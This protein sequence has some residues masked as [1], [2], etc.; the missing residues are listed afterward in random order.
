VE[1][2][3]PSSARANHRGRCWACGASDHLQRDCPSRSRGGRKSGEF[4]KR[5]RRSAVAGQVRAPDSDQPGKSCRSRDSGL[6]NPSVTCITA[7]WFPAMLDFGSSQ[8]FLRL[9]VL[10]DIKRLGLP[11]SVETTER[12]SLLVNGESCVSS[13]VI[14]LG[15]KIH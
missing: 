2:S 15:I 14:V 9:D 13:K 3:T 6:T 1:L 5:P 10:D 4:V 11:H 12:H 7:I 8:S